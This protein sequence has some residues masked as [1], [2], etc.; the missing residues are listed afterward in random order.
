MLCW[1]QSQTVS[2]CPT[3][4]CWRVFSRFL[5]ECCLT[6]QPTPLEKAQSPAHA[7]IFGCVP[8]SSPMKIFLKREAD[9]EER[10][11]GVFLVYRNHPGFFL[12]SW[13]TVLLDA[14]LLS[15]SVCCF[16]YLASISV[17]IVVVGHRV[18]F[19]YL[20]YHV[21]NKSDCETKPWLIWFCCVHSRYPYLKV[22]VGIT[23]RS[24]KVQQEPVLGLFSLYGLRAKYS[25]HCSLLLPE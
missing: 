3:T 16:H 12:C 25:L 4:W 19:V 15:P 21:I 9:W 20:P 7:N 8:T 1:Q 23:L 11:L 5:D 17:E 14:S 2:W 22:A 10:N 24:G 13:T 6:L 18:Y